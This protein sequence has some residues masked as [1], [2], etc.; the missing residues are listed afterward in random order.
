MVCL[1]VETLIDTTVRLG[2][3]GGR[4]S[5]GPRGLTLVHSVV[6]GASHI[7]HASC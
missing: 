4:G 3:T 2:K 1:G 7:D 6:A 5:S